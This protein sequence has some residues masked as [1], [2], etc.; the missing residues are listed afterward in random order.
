MT[1]KTKR[2]LERATFPQ[3]GLD[4]M[5]NTHF[6]EIEMVKVLGE[7]IN[8]YQ[9]DSIENE[10]QYIT[11]LLETWLAH[12]E[13]H[14]AR[15]NNLMETI[16][17]PMIMMHTGE[18]ERALA[19]IKHMVSTWKISE[20]IDAVAEYVFETWPIWFEQHVETMDAI[21]AQFAMMHGYST[22]AEI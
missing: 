16:Q 22:D 7:C 18:H 2:I 6:E 13:T 21:T 11:E 14:F 1:S 17:F 8:S 10:A 20:G 19:E 5:N 9:S 15:E 12:T 3:V 4:V